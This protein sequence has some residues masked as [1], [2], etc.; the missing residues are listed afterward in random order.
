MQET[1]PAEPPPQV[2]AAQLRRELAHEL[3][4]LVRRL[5]QAFPEFE[6]PPF[7]S[8]GMFEQFR[9][10]MPRVPESMQPALLKR[11]RATINE[12][13]FDPE[14]WKGLWYVINYTVQYQTGFFKRRLC[15]RA[16]KDHDRL[17]GSGKDRRGHKQT[18]Y[19]P[20]K[21]AYLAAPVA[22][23]VR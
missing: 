22:F 16:G 21:A 19:Q 20:G 6:P 15:S 17:R 7:S 4:E 14:T 8:R 11:L 12:D 13:L 3:D 9:Q 18:E 10:F 2:D 23:H 5:R 1:L